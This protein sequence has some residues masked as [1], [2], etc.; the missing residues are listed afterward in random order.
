MFNCLPGAMLTLGHTHQWK[1]GF[2]FGCRPVL[3]QHTSVPWRLVPAT[4][5]LA[6][7]AAGLTS[8][9]RPFNFS[10]SP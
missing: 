7:P 2:G 1:K 10:R 8:G 5:N 3:S 4:F 9:Y 6:P